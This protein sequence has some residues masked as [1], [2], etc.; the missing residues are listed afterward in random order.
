MGLLREYWS[1][2]SESGI[3]GIPSRRGLRAI[4]EE[5]SRRDVL[6]GIRH[7][8]AGER[9]LV[10]LSLILNRSYDYGLYFLPGTNL[11][12]SQ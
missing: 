8:R 11:C 7:S 5:S 3:E 10:A 9:V 4:E 2:S 12:A 6:V 1:L